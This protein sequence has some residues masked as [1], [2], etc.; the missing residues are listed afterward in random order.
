MPQDNGC[1][2]LS[3][4]NGSNINCLVIEVFVQN[5]DVGKQNPKAF[6]NHIEQIVKNNAPNRGHFSLRAGAKAELAPG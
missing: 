4:V 3:M 1:P 6:F 5:W 2:A